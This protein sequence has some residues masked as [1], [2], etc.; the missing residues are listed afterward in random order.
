MQAMQK[1]KQGD[2]VLVMDPILRRTPASTM[3]LEKILKLAHQCLASLRH[4]R[5][6]MKKCG[7]VLWGI[8]KEFREK[9]FP[10]HPTF[11]SHHSA[12]Y[13][14]TDS[15]QTRHITFGIEDEDSPKFI[16]A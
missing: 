5:P 3:A 6:S 13:P 4:S 15:R 14:Q 8:R 11:T 2:S 10:P 12:N 16:S 7:E 1:L 9:A